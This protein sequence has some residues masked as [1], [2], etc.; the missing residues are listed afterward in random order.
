MIH[1][2]SHSQTSFYNNLQDFWATQHV[3]VEP[4]VLSP[5]MAVPERH[6]QQLGHVLLP[7]LPLTKLRCSELAKVDSEGKRVDK[8]QK[9][10]RYMIKVTLLVPL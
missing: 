9:K 10:L 5:L 2:H 6:T 1:T 7:W 8:L 3:C 4:E